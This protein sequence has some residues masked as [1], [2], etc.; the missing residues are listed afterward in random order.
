[1]PRLTV[2]VVLD[3]SGVHRGAITDGRLELG[4]EN[5]AGIGRQA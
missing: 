5:G 4:K 2:A 3:L 1:M